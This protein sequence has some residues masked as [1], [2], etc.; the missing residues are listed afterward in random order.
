MALRLL[1]DFD[2]DCVY[3]DNIKLPVANQLDV[4]T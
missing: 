3:I 2:C 1:F 4:V